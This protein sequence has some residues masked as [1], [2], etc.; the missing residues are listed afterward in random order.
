MKFYNAML[1]KAYFEKGYSTTHYVKYMIAFFG[2]ASQDV[3]TTLWI[4]TI[5]AVFCLIIGRL[6]FYYKLVDAEN[7]VYNVV[8]PF[9][10]E[11]RKV[12]K[13]KKLR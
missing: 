8:N 9:V 6:W 10:R 5:Y 13:G 4:G 1:W 12:Y 3:N 7:E 2:I 11:M